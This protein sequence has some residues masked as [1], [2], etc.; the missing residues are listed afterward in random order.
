MEVAWIALYADAVKADG[1]ILAER[2]VRPVVEYSSEGPMVHWSQPKPARALEGF[3]MV[4][5]VQDLTAEQAAWRL[6]DLLRTIWDMPGMWSLEDLGS[7][8]IIRE[9]YQLSD[10]DFP[11]DGAFR[12]LMA[13]L[14]LLAH[15]H[16]VLVGGSWVYRTNT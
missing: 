10:E 15:A 16:Y 11:P 4:H 5:Q 1:G 6:H 13:D 8:D 7:K 9:G 2:A 14:D 3:I 12:P